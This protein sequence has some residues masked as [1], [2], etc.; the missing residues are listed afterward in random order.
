MDLSQREKALLAIAITILLPLALYRFVLIPI[1]DYQRELN[2]RIATL[3]SNIEKANL[4]GQ[5]IDFLKRNTDIRS[6]SL[7]RKMDSLLRQNGLLARSK[8]IVEDQ[9]SGGQRLVLKLDEINLTELANIIYKIEN[10][11]PVLNIENID[12]NP[13]FKDKKLLRVSMAITSF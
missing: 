7:N 10:S 8:L 6:T 11:R 2:R 5:E 9:P 13:S 4:L 3:E 12:I 1:S